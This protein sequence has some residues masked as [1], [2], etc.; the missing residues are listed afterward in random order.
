[1]LQLKNE[2][3]FAPAITVFPNHDGVDTLFVVVRAAFRLEPGTPPLETPP[4]PVQVDEYWGEPGKSSLKYASEYH[5]GKPGTDVV[6]VGSA[7]TPNGR[8][9]PEMLVAVELAGRQKVAVA[10]GD[11]RWR[12]GGRISDPQPFTS[13]PLQWE[14]AFGG[15]HQLGPEPHQVLLEELNPVG[16]GFQGKRTPSDVVGEPLPNIEDARRRLTR[17]G[18]R[19]P[20]VGF[21]FVAAAWLSRRQ[22]AGTYDAA[23]ERKRAPYLP[24]DFDPRFFQSAPPDMI[25]ERPLAGGE[26]LRLTGLSPEGFIEAALPHVSLDVEVR[27]AGATERPPAR[28]ETVLIEPDEKRLSLSFRASLPCDKKVLKVEQVT[29]RAGGSS[30]Q[31]AA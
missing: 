7:H 23:W 1:M 18:D 17:F 22:Y 28:L 16:R 4:P 9:V 2:S 27:I 24:V 8:A 12:S 21:G 31:R 13:M 29:I 3:P 11:R 5:I 15:M 20:P 6:V 14:R 10:L 25:F 19:V 26:R 30:G